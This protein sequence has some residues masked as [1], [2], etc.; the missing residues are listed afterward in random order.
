MVVGVLRVSLEIDGAHSLKEKRRVVR[1]L[2]DRVRQRFGFSVGEVGDQELWNRSE[3][4]A[5]TVGVNEREIQSLL[6]Q[7]TLFVD[8]QAA[9]YRVTGVENWV[10]VF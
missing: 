1:S 10:E 9:E 3:I 4:G 8:E 7:V 6:D 5:V 2:T